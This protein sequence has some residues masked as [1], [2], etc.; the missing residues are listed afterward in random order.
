MKNLKELD[1]QIMYWYDVLH[2]QADKVY[3]TKYY[4]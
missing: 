1:D 3:K 4:L 2:L